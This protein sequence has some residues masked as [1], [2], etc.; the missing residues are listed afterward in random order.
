MLNSMSLLFKH[1]SAP[2]DGTV[3]GVSDRGD[4]DRDDI[5]RI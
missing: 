4:I 2:F 1:F 3:N 5:R